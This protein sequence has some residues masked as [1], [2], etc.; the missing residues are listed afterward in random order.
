M[1]RPL[2]TAL[3]K[4]LGVVR[5]LFWAWRST[6]VVRARL[7]DDGGVAVPVP[8]PPQ[9]PAAAIRGVN[10]GIRLGKAS[11]LERSLVRQRWYRSQGRDRTIIVGVA[12]DGPTAVAHAWL[13]G[14]EHLNDRDYVEMTRVP[15]S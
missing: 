15:A 2:P 7:R 3:T 14:E 6:A 1:T 11:C 5:A 9:L 12:L 8:A 13:E 4:L 10:W